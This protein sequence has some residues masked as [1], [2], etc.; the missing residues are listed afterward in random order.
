[1]R[2]WLK[3]AMH[4]K[5]LADADALTPRMIIYVRRTCGNSQYFKEFT[6]QDSSVRAEMGK[7][8]HEYR[9]VDAP[10]IS[11]AEH[12]KI[13]STGEQTLPIVLFEN[14]AGDVLNSIGGSRALD[15]S[16]LLLKMRSVY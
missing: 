15:P 2:E 6:I 11:M 1:M 9:D 16:A 14:Q 10:T 8:R 5:A 12:A 4:E 13:M 7:F 3:E